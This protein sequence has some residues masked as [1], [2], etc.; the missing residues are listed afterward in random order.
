MQINDIMHTIENNA[1]RVRIFAR[2]GERISRSVTRVPNFAMNRASATSKSEFM[3]YIM[4]C[5]KI[6]VKIPLA[7][8]TQPVLVQLSIRR[9]RLW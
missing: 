3:L 4:I 6:I 9:D 8:I 5:G 1:H 7:N 2:P